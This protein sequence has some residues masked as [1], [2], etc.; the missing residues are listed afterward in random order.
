M[1]KEMMVEGMMCQNCVKH[2]FKALTGLDGVSDVHV[3]LE[4]KMASV[5]AAPSVTDEALK[6]AIEDAG[7]TVTGVHTA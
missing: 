7:Y 3:S 2:V 4:E 1:K 5:V 6:A